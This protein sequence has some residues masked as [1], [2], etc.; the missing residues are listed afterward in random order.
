MDA[1]RST[2]LAAQLASV[3]GERAQ[4]Y[5]AINVRQRNNNS[6]ITT[7]SND[8]QAELTAARSARRQRFL[9]STGCAP[10]SDAGK[11]QEACSWSQ[12]STQCTLDPTEAKAILVHCNAMRCTEGCGKLAWSSRL[13]VIAEKA[14]RQMALRELA[15]SHDGADERFAE[16][17]LGAGDTYGENLARSEGIWPLANNVVNGWRDSPGH[18][19]NILGPFTACGIGVATDC[20]GITFVVQLLAKAPG[21]D[22]QPEGLQED[23]EPTQALPNKNIW[24]FDSGRYPGTFLVLLLAM[25]A[26]KG[27]WFADWL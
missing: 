12:S 19:R 4:A 26:W 17:P 15:F 21:D 2:V 13:A 25:M 23:V 20:S 22:L 5:R 8:F 7:A 24:A 1:T 10:A 3:R 18:C 11:P 27:G 9:Q 16:Y 14:A 6:E